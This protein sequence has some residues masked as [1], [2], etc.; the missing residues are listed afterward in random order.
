MVKSEEII[1]KLQS[2][3]SL[4][5]RKVVE[6]IFN[7]IQNLPGRKSRKT[8]VSDINKLI[9][10]VALKNNKPS[11]LAA[12]PEIEGNE[13]DDLFSKILQQY[14]H[15]DD[16]LWLNTITSL[17]EKLNKKS[18]QSRIFAMIS[19]DLI[20]AGV[21]TANPKFIDQGVKMLDQI[22]FRKYRSEIMIDIIPLL[23]VW[24]ISIRD[25]KL[26]YDSLSNIEE[27]CDISKRAVLHSELAKAMATISILKKNSGY[28]PKASSVR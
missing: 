14:I 10:D 6:G 9:I 12:L 26:L 3:L 1:E 18:Y 20:D 13:I 7:D 16:E 17:S 28:F 2:E 23:I 11:I 21:T 19:R 24:A 8:I 5:D 22:S 4:D 25:E 15:T 27:I